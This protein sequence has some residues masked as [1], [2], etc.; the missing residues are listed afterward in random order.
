MFKRLTLRSVDA[1]AFAFAFV[2][3]RIHQITPVAR[4]LGCM[5][6][7]REAICARIRPEPMFYRALKR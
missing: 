3:G 1:F 4:H 2:L 5:Q 7:E 6:T